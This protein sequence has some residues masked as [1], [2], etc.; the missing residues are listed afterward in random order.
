MND[1]EL[2]HGIKKC[3]PPFYVKFGTNGIFRSEMKN[4][5][6]KT[7]HNEAKLTEEGNDT[8]NNKGGLNGKEKDN[9]AV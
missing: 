5:A 1:Q 9:Q 6:S 3:D 8:Q 2:P 7:L 4:K